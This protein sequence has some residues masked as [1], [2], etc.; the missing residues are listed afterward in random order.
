MTDTIESVPS[1]DQPGSNPRGVEVDPTSPYA[2]VYAVYTSSDRAQIAALEATA[3]AFLAD[4]IGH[5]D[6]INP[7]PGSPYRHATF[8]ETAWRFVRARSGTGD[9]SDDQGETCGDGAVSSD[10]GGSSDAGVSPGVGASSD[11]EV[12]DLD[13]ASLPD[14]IDAGP[15]TID[16]DPG[17]I[18]ADPGSIDADP[19]NTGADD[20]EPHVAAPAEGGPETRGADSTQDADSAFL[21]GFPKFSETQTMDG[22]VHRFSHTEDVAELS[23]IRGSTVSGTYAHIVAAMTLVHGLPKFHA[24]C[25]AGEFTIEHILAAAQACRHLRF[26]NLHAVDRYLDERRADITIETFKKSLAMKIAV[27]QPNEER[28]ESA[29]EHRRVDLTTYPDGTACLTLTGSS[30]DLQALYVRIEAFAKL[31]R[32]GSTAAIADQLPPGAVIDDDRGIAALMF[33]IFTRTVPQV[34]IQVRAHDT[35]TGE[36]TTTEIPL[37][38]DDVRTAEDIDAAVAAAATAAADSAAATTTDGSADGDLAGRSD[39]AGRPDAAVD[40]VN[41]GGNAAEAGADSARDPQDL[42][43]PTSPAVRRRLHRLPGVELDEFG[44]VAFALTVS[45]P[46]DEF[47]MRAQAKMITT[48]PCMSLAQ[49]ADLPGTFSDGSPVP[50][51]TARYIAAHSRTWTRILTDP[52]TGTPI[53]VKA[54]SYQIPAAIRQTLIAQWRGCTA[55]G[56]R[57]RAETSEIDHIIPFDHDDPASG[58]KTVFGNLHPLCKQHHQAKTDGKYSVRM[59]EPGVVE[60]RFA[61][62]STATVSPPD[63]PVNA[64]N[65]RLMR[66]IGDADPPGPSAPPDSSGPSDKP[67]TPG[68]WSPPDSPDLPNSPDTPDPPARPN[69][70]VHSQPPESWRP[71]DS[72]NPPDQLNPPDQSV[73]ADPSTSRVP[74]DTPEPPRLF[75]PNDAPRAPRLPDPNDAPCEQ[76]G[77]VRR[78]G[79]VRRSA[80][81][82]GPVGGSG[83]PGWMPK[84][85]S[86]EWKAPQGR[87]WVWDNGE[88]PPF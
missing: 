1:A 43:S 65:A 31:I 12:D 15:G 35:D 2:D 34:S 19:G 57:R 52:A 85:G 33:D 28:T 79:E 80:E 41:T 47:W 24:R 21:P 77:E 44:R 16:Q 29:R 22:W 76:G 8:S 4:V 27:L 78:A 64:E 49:Q 54:L 37:D 13:D 63:H 68:P 11:A 25:A 17:S 70:A 66:D 61:H 20:S 38:L 88:P 55:P 51:E 72:P 18:D 39:A 87:E 81:C 59:V 62:G 67:D 40:A 50:A 6:L 56:C 3:R 36:T 53:D 7:D 42:P 75:D 69:S 5:L 84:F 14:S 32:N 73:P 58:G 74:S 30:A 83:H 45:M 82:P 23:A 46:T 9:E 10:T 71:P 48:V 26:T 86:I 60:Y